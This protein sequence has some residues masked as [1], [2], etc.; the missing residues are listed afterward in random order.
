M[1]TLRLLLTAVLLH[2]AAAPTLA[3][4]A[5]FRAAPVPVFTPR[6]APQL[7]T[8]LTLTPV[9]QPGV[10]IHG[11]L[12]PS[13]NSGLPKLT[14]SPQVQGLPLAETS[15][16]KEAVLPGLN[17]VVEALGAS[18]LGGDTAQQQVL[19]GYFEGRKISAGSSLTELGGGNA[20]GSNLAPS[21]KSN[22]SKDPG[23][24]TVEQKPKNSFSRALKVGTIGAVVPMLLSNLIVIGALLLGHQFT[25][26]YE[27]PAAFVT[28]TALALLFAVIASVMAPVAEEVV[29]RSMAMKAAQKLTKTFSTFWAPAVLTSALFV[30][31]HETGDPVLMTTRFIH[32]MILARVYHKEGLPA[33]MAAHALFNAIPALALIFTMALGPSLGGLAAMAIMPAGLYLS[34]RFYKQLKAQP[35]VE[36]AELTPAQSNTLAA[37]LLSG[38]FLIAPVLWWPVGAAALF[39]HAFNTRKKT[40]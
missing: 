20:G 5:R 8:G 22:G 7:K 26:T 28:N 32:A 11:G 14:V 4:T 17:N 25:P 38:F 35:E 12:N 19:D 23:E 31:I 3:A 37:L 10:F 21:G 39:W 15:A 30:S 18:P 1:N 34:W 40:A 24:K 6:V 27:N 36:R 16:A 13:L 29:F 33:A 9:F 2:S